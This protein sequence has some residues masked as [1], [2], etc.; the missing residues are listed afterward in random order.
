MSDEEDVKPSIYEVF[1]VISGEIQ[2]FLKF[3]FV[4]KQ[5]GT[6]SDEECDPYADIDD[7]DDGD[8]KIGRLT[9]S[10]DVKDTR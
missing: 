1:D 9:C 6:F 2:F 10:H 5:L 8:Y 7:Y 3:W 4:D